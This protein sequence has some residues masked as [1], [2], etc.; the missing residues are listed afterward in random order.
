MS[1]EV[2]YIRVR[3]IECEPD[4]RLKTSYELFDPYV[5]VQ[6]LEAQTEP[7]QSHWFIFI[8]RVWFCSHNLSGTKLLMHTNTIH[9]GPFKNHVTLTV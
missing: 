8:V 3:L 9:V 1:N 7:G 6:V 4:D 5:I 2:D